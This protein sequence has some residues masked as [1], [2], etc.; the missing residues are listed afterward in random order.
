MGSD[1]YVQFDPAGIEQARQIDRKR[2]IE[3]RLSDLVI[4]RYPR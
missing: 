3:P 4:I 2:E 1:R